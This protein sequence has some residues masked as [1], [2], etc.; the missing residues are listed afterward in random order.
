MALFELNDLEDDALMT[1]VDRGEDEEPAEYGIDFETGQLTGE[2]VYGVDALAVWAWMAVQT[3]RYRWMLYSDDYGCEVQDL[4]GTKHSKA[5]YKSLISA[6]VSE[7][8][9]QNTRI[10][11]IANLEC[12]VQPTYI[13]LSFEIV[14]DYG[15]KELEVEL[16]V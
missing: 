16:D 1:A 11:G 10:S 7:C 2:I 13:A 3:I 4:I 6:L 12:D 15:N 8:V 5:Y 9:T 14:T